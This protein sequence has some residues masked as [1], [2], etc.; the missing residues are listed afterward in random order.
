[1]MDYCHDN[2]TC[3][4]S[5]NVMIDYWKVHSKDATLEEM[6]LDSKAQTLN[7]MEKPEILSLLPAFEGKR[8]LEL[9]A[10]IGRFTGSIA[11]AA[12]HVTAV[13]FMESFIQKNQ[14]INGHHKN[15]EFVQADVTEMELLENSFDVVFSNWLMMYLTDDEVLQLAKNALSWLKEDGFM[16]FRESC[17]HQSG[18]RKRNVNPSVYRSPSLYNAL[19]QS[20]S[21]AIDGDK[22]MVM[23]FDVVYT[24]S[25]QTYIKLKKNQNQLCWLVQK[26]RMAKASYHGYNTFQSFLDNQQYSKQGILRYEK[27]FGDGYVSTGGPETTKEF[28]AMLNLQPGQKVM[29]VGCGIG[30]GDFYMAKTYGASVLGVDLS[31]NMIEVAMERSSEQKGN[32]KVQ[33]E[34]SDITK[35]DFPE[36]SFDVVYSRDTILHIP[37]KPA[38]FST[39]LK[40]TKPGG[41]LLI[42]DY[43]CGPEENH[44]I[45]FKKYVAQRGYILYTPQDYGKLIESAGFITVKAEDR[46]KQFVDV[47]EREKKR[48]MENKDEFLKEFSEED[49]QYLMDGW[50]SKLKRC[51]AGDQ[52]WGL[53][54]A[55]K[56]Q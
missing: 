52:R 26:K 38:L 9:G 51:A 32:P 56:A 19:F 43:C 8:V 11:A 50:N 22:D 3:D 12:S 55:E 48:L 53:F 13:D 18:D 37:D 20:V 10:G 34:V 16:F 17:F 24:K 36:G 39:F 15:A 21:Q 1:M 7:Q 23:G 25:V 35:R 5:R 41:K 29:D 40:W 47:L 28:V 33:F 2:E 14:Q 46:T 30:G 49:Y 54:Y 44:S 27:I 31:C 42:S 4:E 45:D 6:M